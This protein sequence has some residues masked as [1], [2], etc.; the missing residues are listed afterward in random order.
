M[1]QQRQLSA[2]MFTDIVGYTALMQKDENSAVHIRTKHREIFNAHIQKHNGELIQYY[3]DGTLSIFKSSVEAVKCGID[4]QKAFQ[5]EPTIPVRIGIH[6]GDIIKTESDIIGDAVNVASRIESVGVAGSVLISD[7]VNDQL[8][9]QKDIETKFLDVFEFKNVEESIP[10]YSV[11]SPGL[12]V[13]ELSS[14]QGKTKEKENKKTFL[15]LDNY[16]QELK[17]RN[18]IRAALS[19]IV[20]AW[21]IIQAASIFF[22]TFG[23]SEDAM[24]ILIISLSVCFPFWIVFAYVFEWTSS[25]FKK[26]KDVAIE[27]SNRKAVRKKMN[28]A[29]IAGLSL[30]V[31]LLVSDRIFNFTKSSESTEI[32]KSIAVLAFTDMSP[33]KDQE[34]FSD[35]ISEEI[36]NL[37]AKIPDLKVIGRT[38]SFSFKNKEATIQEIGKTLNVN[39]LLQ[40][41]I[42]KFGNNFRITAQLINVADGTYIWSETYERSIDDIFLIQDEI[43]LEVTHQLK[44]S[45]MG[46]TIT[47]KT[48]TPEAYTL[49]LQAKQLVD[50]ISSESIENAEKLIRQ[51]I[52]I[53]SMYAPS[54]VL[55]GTVIYKNYFVYTT[56]GHSL[57]EGIA[58]TKAAAKK[59]IALDIDYALGYA[60]MAVCNRAEWD[61]NAANTNIQRAIQL[62]PDDSYVLKAAASHHMQFGKLEEAIDLLKKA[63]SLDPLNSSNFYNLSNYYTWQEHDKEAEAAM[64]KYLLMNPNSGMGHNVMSMIY[65]RQGKIDQA[66][67]EADKDQHPFWNIYRKSMIFYKIGRTVESDSLVQQIKDTFGDYASPNIAFIYASRGDK[68]NAFKWIEIAYENKDVVLLEILNYPEMKNLWGDPRWNA[69]INKLGLPDDHGFHSD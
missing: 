63:I 39:H 28:G 65:L 4:M 30:A 38:S 11:V 16:I 34:Y 7:K 20:F 56:E 3:G 23:F 42:R 29:I 52:A 43:A 40:G 58:L 46:K 24:S 10:V 2:I 1:S 59:A 45:L 27:S 41:S 50:Q 68:D 9:N 57:S 64:Q 15:D 44:I 54:W 12:V 17:R 55:L 25:G 69:F 14:I 8:K 48:V 51:S 47:S 36:L 13:P 19:F 31:I 32:D 5:T 6:V 33:E 35:G 37:L 49:Y 26:T 67:I 18:V 61:F 62:A 22:P 60:L 21:V 66:L 53:D